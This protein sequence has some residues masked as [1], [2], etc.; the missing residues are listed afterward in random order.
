MRRHKQLT[1]NIRERLVRREMSQR[2]LAL[3]IHLAPTAL[4][5]RLRGDREFRF[6][7]LEAIAEALGC[8]LRD[9][10]TFDGEGVKV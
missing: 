2:D 3:A 8:S 4:S 6:C 7:E 10:M 5:A 1:L 9:L